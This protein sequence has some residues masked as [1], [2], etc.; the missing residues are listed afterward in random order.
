MNRGTKKSL[1]QLENV[2]IAVPIPTAIEDSAQMCAQTISERSSVRRV[3][4][5]TEI[6]MKPIQINPDDI[7]VCDVCAEDW[8]ERR[9]TGGGIVDGSAVCPQCWQRLDLETHS[10]VQG[11]CTVG[12][13]WKDWIREVRT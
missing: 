3:S 1:I 2:S 4:C 13:D 6:Q 10:G 9:G 7:V 5:D 11:R 8:T 12:M